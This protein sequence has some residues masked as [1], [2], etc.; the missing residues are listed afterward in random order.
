MIANI[1]GFAGPA[2]IGLLKTR[3]GTYTDAFLLLGGLAVIATLLALRIGS[4]QTPRT[5]QPAAAN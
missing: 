3:T 5:E 4:R 2:L 1:G